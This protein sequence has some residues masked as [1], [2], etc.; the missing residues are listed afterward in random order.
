MAILVEFHR[1][2]DSKTEVKRYYRYFK[3]KDQLCKYLIEED[4]NIESYKII[5]ERGGKRSLIGL[6]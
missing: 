1:N 3:N 4:D 6:E 5:A 2:G